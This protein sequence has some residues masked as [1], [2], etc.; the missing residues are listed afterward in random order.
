MCIR[1]RVLK[2]LIGILVFAHVFML[3]ASLPFLLSAY[4]PLVGG[5]YTAQVVMPLGWGESI[6]ASGSW[7]AAS[8][9][10]EEKTAVSGI[11]PSLVPFFPG[12][13][14]FEETSGWEEADYVILT[15]NTK[16][17]DPQTLA[18]ADQELQLNHTVQFGLLPQAWIYAN[19]NARPLTI[20]V[21]PLPDPPS[22][23]EQ[24]R[25]LGQDIRVDAQ[26][27]ELLF[28]ARWQKQEADPLLTIK[29]HLLDEAGNIWQE[30]ETELLNDVYFYPQNWAVS[31]T[32]QVTYRLDLPP[33]MP[34]GTYFVTLSLVDQKTGGQLPVYSAQQSGGVVYNAGAIALD[35]PLQA[36]A[37]G[38]LEM[39]RLSD[40]AWLDG[41]LRLL[42]Y[43][44]ISSPVQ[45][46]GDVFVELIWQAGGP[47]P[48]GLQLALELEGAELL[49]YPLSSFDTAGWTPGAV[50]RQKYTYPV[51][52][53]L[54]EGDYVLSA[55][56][57]D[58]SGEML[59]E[60]PA[61]IGEVRVDAVDRLFTLPDGIEV[62]LEVRFEPGV[63]LQGISPGGITAGPG[64]NFALTL[65]WQTEVQ[66]A[67]PVTTFLHLL[68]GNGQVL[69]QSDQ[70]PG[71]LPSNVWSPSQVIVDKHE[72][73][74]PEDISGGEYQIV[75]GLYT[76]SDGRRLPAFD[77]SGE[78]IAGD[79]FILP[80][81]VSVTE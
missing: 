48:A 46:G 19:P 68:D 52:G 47:L 63:L 24:M 34:P 32:P 78:R 43:T 60:L 18:R 13:T 27:E 38:Q 81:V 59:A 16:Q 30:L 64:E 66:T 6:S 50:L 33:G 2:V 26:M 5:P 62:P 4:N 58:S 10:A 56:L 35:F 9:G 1:D 17:V 73:T 51:P 14:L 55:A 45:A 41:D 53:D 39:T 80:I 72:L 69:A 71:G 29:I 3:A 61:P 7:L 65:Y 15:A 22:F 11:A 36:L 8:P 54:P 49:T 31:E 12:R 28:T 23:G 57:L 40:A 20:K 67:E 76:A 25:L 74:L 42:G 44:D 21:E 79:Q 77:R 70:W 37:P 75:T